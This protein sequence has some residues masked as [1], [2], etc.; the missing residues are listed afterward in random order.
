MNSLIVLA[1][2]TDQ[3][4]MNSRCAELILAAETECGAFISAAKQLFGEAM[5]LRAGYLWVEALEAD[6][7]FR[8]Q[9]SGLRLATIFAAGKLADLMGANSTIALRKPE[10]ALI[11]DWR[12]VR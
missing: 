6:T 1:A 12:A 5:A 4:H 3:T 8:C 2:V 7:S 11:T 10:E 9:H